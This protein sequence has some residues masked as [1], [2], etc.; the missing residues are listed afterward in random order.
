MMKYFTYTVLGIVILLM[1]MMLL[2]CIVTPEKTVYG[3]YTN[4]V[5]YWTSDAYFNSNF[6]V[7]GD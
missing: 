6:V 4:P 5:K 7:K 1:I 3:E 2:M